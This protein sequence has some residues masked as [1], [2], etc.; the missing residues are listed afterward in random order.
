MKNGLTEC[1][2]GESLGSSMG[3]SRS[4]PAHSGLTVTRG[5]LNSAIADW[6]EK[7]EVPCSIKDKKKIM[8]SL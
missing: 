1:D 7:M 3:R 5:S 4:I 8:H 2:A 6:M